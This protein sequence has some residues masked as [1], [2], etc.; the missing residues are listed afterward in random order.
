MSPGNVSDPPGHA[1]RASRRGRARNRTRN[2]E[3]LS[4]VEA[5]VAP[6]APP[7]PPFP[8]SRPPS[9]AA[10]PGGAFPEVRT[11]VVQAP[12]SKGPAG[13]DPSSLAASRDLGARGR[14]R[15]ARRHE[16]SERL[17]R[18]RR[19]I[20]AA[21][22]AL[23]LLGGGLVAVGW[24]QVRDSTPGEYVDASRSPD[25]PG[26]V[27]LV[28]PTPTML[29]ATVDG[30]GGL[31]GVALLALHAEDQGGAVLVMPTATRTPLATE[32]DTT[33]SSDQTD[34]AGATGDTTTG[35]TNT[36]DTTVDDP[37]AGEGEE[38][39]TPSSVDT[40]I[41]PDEG[42]TLAAAYDD[43][44]LGSVV[45]Q[46]ERLLNVAVL[47]SV[48]LDDTGWTSLVAPVNPLTVT[49]DD[50]VGDW[51]TGD[52]ELT[53]EEVGPFL[54]ARNE[55][56]S[57]LAR[58]SRQELL[59]RA[60]LPEVTLGGAEAVPGEASVGIGR[61]VRGLAAGDM[62]VNS[63]PVEPADDVFEEQFVAVQAMMV[64]LVA[65]EIPYPQEPTPGGRIR[66]RLLNGTSD[67]DLA[68]HAAAPLVAAGAEIA[69]A[70]N[71]TSFQEP[72]TRLVYATPQ[73]R[74]AAEALQAA[75][76]IGVV[77]EEQSD[78]GI[79]S[80]EEGDR[81]D[82]TVILGADAPEAIGRLESPD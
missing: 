70:G 27:A 48:E 58:L 17:R 19:R 65:Q 10:P 3:G 79:P 33:A 14:R 37:A 56:E 60:W 2:A 80:T 21:L 62:T 45:T 32:D 78:E 39:T 12:R 9:G 13:L 72:Q 20:V 23:I 38:V 5:Y 31:A 43:G 30:D 74:E 68:I 18:S 7:P 41:G 50:A 42:V 67:E 82:V 69:V 71:A 51:S 16:R 52:V 15:A 75:L 4:N 66:V 28:E 22:C 49:L 1:R 53:A 46:V 54:A 47:E 11:W 77:E 76:G 26:Y 6:S 73:Q 57:E 40:E 59:W 25:E 61:F 64:P 24:A 55:E 63:L 29:V 34:G 8:P 44:G 35:D 36:G 81:I